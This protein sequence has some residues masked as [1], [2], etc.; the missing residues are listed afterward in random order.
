[1]TLIIKVSKIHRA[2]QFNQSNWL[3]VFVD[4]N[5]AR[6]TSA[7]NDFE[8]N[9]YKL[10][11]NAIFGKSI[12]NQRKEKDIRAVTVWDSRY[13]AEA[14]IASPDFHSI[15]EINENHAIIQKKRTEIEIRRPIY[16]G[17]AILDISKTLMYDFH[18]SKMKRWVE[19]IELCYMDTD[20]FIYEI[21]GTDIYE[22]MKER[23]EWFDTSNFPEDNQ[24]GIEQKNAKVVGKFKNET[25]SNILTH[26]I[27]LR[28]KMY[29]LLIEN[30]P[31]VMKAKGVKASAVRTITFENYEECLFKK[32]DH[33]MSADYDS[34]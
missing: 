2:L 22:V 25:S 7:T 14:C 31:P 32:N 26:F 15:A 27:G 24:F 11:V 16:I 5:T 13:G 17:A 19:S 4:F 6:R 23:S 33:E 3:Q 20:S 30:E 8:R 9:L 18:Y 10:L 12:Q 1:M 34:F 29:S 21:K 28:S